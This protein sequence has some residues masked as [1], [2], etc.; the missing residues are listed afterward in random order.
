LFRPYVQAVRTQGALLPLI[1]SFVGGGL[2]I[3]ML[4][5][6]VLLL[7][8]LQ[9]GSFLGA[10]IMAAAL[11]AGN[12][13][14]V[15]VQ[16]ALI[17]RRGQT[18]VLIPASL[19]CLSSLVAFVFVSAHG[20]PPELSAGLALAGGAAIP[21]TPSSMRVLWAALI[22]D[23]RLR[24]T[25][26]ALS[27]VSFPMATILGPVLV[28]G[29]LLLGGPRVAV[30][31]AAGLA[32]GGGVIFALTPASRH[33]TPATAHAPRHAPP[34]ETGRPRGRFSRRRFSRG[35]RT[36][37]IGNAAI[38]LTAGLGGVAIPAAAI[39]L[40]AVAL[41]GVFGAAVAAG[42]LCGGLAYGSRRWRLPLASRLVAAQCGSAIAGVGLAL[43][44]G[45][46]LGMMLVM[47]VNGAAGAVQGITATTLLDDVASPSALT[48][49]Y[50]LLVSGGL[51]GSAAGYAVGGTLV[52]A[53]GAR[54]MF[55]VAAVVGLAVAG[56]YARRVRTLEPRP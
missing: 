49:S 23:P 11:S 52:S 28:S 50:A 35:M 56:W 36:L 31:V 8:R 6:A 9:S 38:G 19:T 51:A 42:D 32:G 41:S 47:P 12:A 29:L 43:A 40:G 15:A 33:W 1:A 34:H 21:A 54:G 2:P 25:A 13:A 30:L 24:M 46:I 27:A 18:V 10:G 5:L 37:I 17:D 20:G 39:A 44:S 48:G 45:S 22:A 53:V 55:L 16:G 7:V 4:T 26:Y 14:G 3:G